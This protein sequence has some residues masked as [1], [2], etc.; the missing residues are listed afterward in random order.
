MPF[1]SEPVHFSGKI[2]QVAWAEPAART[3]S[4]HDERGALSRPYSDARFTWRDGNLYVFLYAA[5]ENIE[6]PETS[7][8]ELAH[9][10]FRLTFATAED[11][12]QLEVSARGAMTASL[13]RSDGGTGP[14]MTSAQA[15]TDAEETVDDPTDEDEEWIVELTVPLT[16]LGLHGAAGE[17][18][19]LAIERCDSLR[20]GMRAC[21]SWGSLHSPDLR[22]GTPLAGG[23]VP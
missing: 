21:G 8:Q 12:R 20:S 17:P 11:T 9:D 1:A 4:F 13:T 5:D 7:G 19:A 23:S 18:V 22:L 3:G 10:A 2:E 14:W 6:A 16:S 15:V